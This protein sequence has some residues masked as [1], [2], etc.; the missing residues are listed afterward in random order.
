[1]K[2]ATVVGAC[3]QFVK[4]GPVSHEL[5]KVATEVLI[6][7]GQHYDDNMS[8]FRC[9]LAKSAQTVVR[10]AHPRTRKQLERLGMDGRSNLL[11]IDLPSSANST[12]R[13]K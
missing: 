8:A 13:L 4:C 11:T 6:H 2:V 1:M 9:A 7:T 5:R 3:P 10:P 12:E